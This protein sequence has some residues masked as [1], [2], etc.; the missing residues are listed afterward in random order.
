[1]AEESPD[2]DDLY[3]F[4]KDRRNHS[5]EA[6]NGL[7]PFYN[8]RND[9]DYVNLEHSEP[10]FQ[11]EYLTQKSLPNLKH[12]NQYLYKRNLL[13]ESEP[14]LGSNYRKRRFF[15]NEAIEFTRYKRTEIFLFFYIVC[16]VT[17]LI[18]GSICFQRLE[19]GAE[20]A[21]RREFREAREDFLKDH[22]SVT[23]KNHCD[24]CSMCAECFRSDDCVISQ[25][26]VY[27]FAAR[28]CEDSH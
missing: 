7:E 19:Y 18:G 9:Y 1:M 26:D 11:C 3:I 21:I 12:S 22:P 13:S 20:Q 8:S 15:C 23:G 4:S 5:G 16:Y 25:E 10:P 14:L 24:A 2:Y 6:V 17:F 28:Q 27:I